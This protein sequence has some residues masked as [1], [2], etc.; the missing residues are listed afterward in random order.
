MCEAGVGVCGC[1]RVPFQGRLVG[2]GPRGRGGAGQ[3]SRE[4]GGRAL[5]FPPP[6][7]AAGR[8][9]E[10]E[11]SSLSTR[12]RPSLSLSSSYLLGQLAGE[13]LVQLGVEDAVGDELWVGGEGGRGEKGGE[14][15]AAEEGSESGAEAQWAHAHRCGKGRLIPASVSK[16][17][18]SLALHGRR[19]WCEEGVGRPRRGLR[20]RGPGRRRRRR[21]GQGDTSSLPAARPLGFSSR[22]HTTP[23]GGGGSPGGSTAG[24]RGRESARSPRRARRKKRPGRL[25]ISPPRR[26]RAGGSSPSRARARAAFP[27]SLSLS[28]PRRVEAWDERTLRFLEMV[29]TMA[30]DLCWGK[31]AGGGRKKMTVKGRGGARCLSLCLSLCTLSTAAR[32]R[33]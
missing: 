29:V 9:S 4:A 33:S 28:E 22:R 1:V 30:G 21:P 13:Q 11:H 7:S 20:P 6:R 3:E 14:E 27:F 15:R 2:R 10:Q 31:A 8:A 25:S 18:P 17:R 5:S 16:P 32:A 19:G 12:R 23:G 26:R 24:G